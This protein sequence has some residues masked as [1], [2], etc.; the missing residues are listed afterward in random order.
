MMTPSIT[1]QFLN[2]LSFNDL[3]FYSTSAAWSKDR[4]LTLSL[5][6]TAISPYVKHPVHKLTT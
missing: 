2:L 6:I 3:V 1:S 4:F 5:L